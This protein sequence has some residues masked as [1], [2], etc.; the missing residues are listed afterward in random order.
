MSQQ[1]VF[2]LYV[3]TEKQRAAHALTRESDDVTARL[4]PT[5]RRFSFVHR[6]AGARLSLPN[7]YTGPTSLHSYSTR[8][9]A[10]PSL[11]TSSVFFCNTLLSDQFY[12]TL[13][14]LLEL[15]N[16]TLPTALLGQTSNH[17]RVSSIHRHPDP[18]AK[19]AA[20]AT[21]ARTPP[22]TSSS[23]P[24]TRRDLAREGTHA[25]TTAR[26]RVTELGGTKFPSGD[27]RGTGSLRR[28][29]RVLRSRL[30]R[31]RLD[32]LGR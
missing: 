25:R 19:S 7:L 10:R 27:R 28:R 31:L 4:L 6:A 32:D 22:M 2:M 24:D 8:E 26:A 23:R 20:A 18:V 21:R 12:S 15:T 9:R 29:T 1:R 17:Y 13:P 5:L 3:K 16:P 14:L 11:C 30:L